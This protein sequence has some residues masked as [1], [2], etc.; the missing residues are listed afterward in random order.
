[1]HEFEGEKLYTHPGC[2][3]NIKFQKTR[4]TSEGTSPAPPHAT[5]AVRHSNSSVIGSA[6]TLK[7]S[8]YLVRKD[9]GNS[10][11]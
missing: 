3:T 6:T 4:D 2:Q 5:A 10:G 8:E 1:M 11:G 9:C 7:N